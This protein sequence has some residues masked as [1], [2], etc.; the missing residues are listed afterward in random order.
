M[1][2][3]TDTIASAIR[4]T[5]RLQESIDKATNNAFGKLAFELRSEQQRV[6]R[7]SFKSVV[8]YTLNAIRA[9]TPK[10]TGNYQTAG[11]YFI[12]QGAKGRQAHKYLTPNIKGGGRRFK[13]H[14][15]ALFKAGLIP[16]G[17]YT[18][19]GENTTLRNGGQYQRMLSQLKAQPKE[20]MNE[21]TASARRKR[22]TSDFFVM[23]RGSEPIAIARRSAGSI[24]VELAITQTKPTY[25]PIYDFYG[26]SMAYTKTNF[27]RLFDSQMRRFT[28]GSR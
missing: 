19:K 20:R 8:P 11:V 12:E 22:R 6:M 14:E 27:K 2:N 18:Q 21:T 17:A 26:T 7:V 28:G 16:A 3:V 13:P 24:T 15:V 5:S 10:A 25:K 4:R 1:I 23:Y 9:R